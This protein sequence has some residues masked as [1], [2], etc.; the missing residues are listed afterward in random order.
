MLGPLNIQNIVGGD[1]PPWKGI[2]EQDVRAAITALKAT[3][4]KFVALSPHDSSDWSID[5]FRDAFGEQYHD[6]KVGR[7]LQ[8]Q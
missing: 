7:E 6:L 1:T 3:D 2:G 4:P 5:K 8:L